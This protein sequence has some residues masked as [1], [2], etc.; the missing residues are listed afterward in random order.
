MAYDIVSYAIFFRLKSFH[1][2]FFCNLGISFLVPY[3]K[4]FGRITQF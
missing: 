4:D 2:K 3:T 1:M